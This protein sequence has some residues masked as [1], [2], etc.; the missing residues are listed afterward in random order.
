MRPQRIAAHTILVVGAL[1]LPVASAAS[2][3]T[4]SDPPGRR[5]CKPGFGHGDA[6]HRHCGPPG[7]SGSTEPGTTTSV[8]VTTT[9]VSVTTTTL[10]PTT[11]GPTTTTIP[12]GTTTT[13]VC[14]TTTTTAPATTTTSLFPPTT[15]PGC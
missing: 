15:V 11:V 7:R 5:P 4:E 10:V 12:G 8:P 6:N 13:T 1:L 9:T 3:R 14:T 2:A